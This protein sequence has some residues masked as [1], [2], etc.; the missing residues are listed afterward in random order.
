MST[1]TRYGTGQPDLIAAM[2]DLRTKFGGFRFNAAQWDL[3]VRR[4]H[5]KGKLAGILAL[6]S[7]PT[8]SDA[9][10]AALWLDDELRMELEELADER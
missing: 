5:A 9:Q 4:H 7:S 6:P 8:L 2:N 10:I 1:N 3:M